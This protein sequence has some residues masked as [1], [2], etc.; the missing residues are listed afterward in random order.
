[1]HTPRRDDESAVSDH[2]HL[3]LTGDGAVALRL[4][5]GDVFYDLL[6]LGELLSSSSLVVPRGEPYASSCA[7]ED[8]EED[9]QEHLGTCLLLDASESCSHTTGTASLRRSAR[10]SHRRVSSV[11]W[12]IRAYSSSRSGR[13]TWAAGACPDCRAMAARSQDQAAAP[14]MRA[15]AKRM[16]LAVVIGR[17]PF[18]PPDCPQ[19][20]RSGPGRHIPLALPPIGDCARN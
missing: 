15:R 16:R 11:A 8:H 18:S 14:T 10:Y 17:P 4:D 19:N 3:R 13:A 2:A 20:R 5:V 7:R 9:E 12:S 6:D 1:M